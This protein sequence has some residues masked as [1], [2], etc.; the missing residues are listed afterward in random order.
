MPNPIATMHPTQRWSTIIRRST[1]LVIYFISVCSYFA[2]CDDNSICEHWNECGSLCY[3]N[4][5]HQNG[6]RKRLA[7]KTLIH[8]FPCCFKQQKHDINYACTSHLNKMS[9]ETWVSGF[10]NHVSSLVNP[11]YHLNDRFLLA[12]DLAYFDTDKPCST[13]WFSLSSGDMLNFPAYKNKQQN[14]DSKEK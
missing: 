1:Y 4:S 14:L 9:N 6:K 5:S 11:F 12:Y 3:K 13:L 7:H 10:T 2:N 8:L